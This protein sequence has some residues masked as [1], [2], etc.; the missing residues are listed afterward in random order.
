MD[1]PR[2]REI[3]K[4]A[5]EQ[6]GKAANEAVQQVG[7][8]VQ[9]ALDQGKAMVQ[10]LA[11][12]ASETGRQPW[13]GRASFW[14]TWRRRRK[15]WGAISTSAVLSRQSTHANPSCSNPSPRC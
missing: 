8:R 2:A 10:T 12:Q 6:V 13:T 14:R 7:A 1:Q 9:P 5:A 11:S 3:A 4:D 15:K